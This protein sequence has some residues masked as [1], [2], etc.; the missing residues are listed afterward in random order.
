MK[1]NIYFCLAFL[2]VASAGIAQI[3]NN[4]FENWTSGGS[5][6]TPDQWGTLNP[7]T[8]PAS[9][10]TCVKGTPGN[11]GTAYLSLTSK[12]VISTVAPGVAV[13]GRINSSTYKADRGFPFTGQ[14]AT[15]TGSWQYMSGGGGDAGFVSVLFTKWNSGTGKEDTIAYTVKPLAGMVMSWTNFSIP[16][17]YK[18]TATPDSAM[19]VLSASGATPFNGSYLY[20]DN[21]VFAGSVAGIQEAGMPVAFGL[22]PNPA[23]DMLTIS[24]ENGNSINTIELFDIQG[25]LVKNLEVK[26]RSE[27]FTVDITS[28]AKGCYL[29]KL[30]SEKG[31]SI[32]K[33]VK[34]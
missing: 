16:L 14:P 6:N 30:N 33:F 15:L 24:A 5:Y 20:I 23:Q 11:P 34:N 18:R 10:Y 7:T 32:R 21:L 28:L 17:T 22:Y 31:F 25:Q 19:I 26:N 8:A 29:V 4:S 27:S 2:S 3:P 12:T 1:K 13:S 9:V